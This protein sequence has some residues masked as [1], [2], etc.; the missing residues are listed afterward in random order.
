MA[1]EVKL[2][3]RGFFGALAAVGGS[4][5]ALE[6]A[7]KPGARPRNIIWMVAD[8]MSP[9]VLPMAEH[10][11]RMVRGKGLLW[12]AL[13]DRR[14][15][16]R[17]LMDMASLN[18][19]VTDSS[20]ASSSWGSG[21]RIFNGMVNM[22]PDGTKL[23]PLAAIA[24]DKGKRVGLVTTAT[25][26]HATPAG[27][28]SAERRRDDEHLIAEQY[29]RNADVI[30]GG[31]LKF[32]DA[33]TRK[34]GKDLIGEFR[35][36]GYAW[37]ARKQSLSAARN[38]DK[39][40]GLFS[41]SHVPYTIDHRADATL[42]QNVPTLAE[43][44]GAALASLSRGR[45]GFLLQVEGARVDHAAHNNDAAALLW[46]QIAF[47]DAIEVVLQFAE[48][49]PETLVVITSDHGNS[50]PGLN[51]MGDEYTES[52]KCFERLA[53]ITRSFEHVNPRLGAKGEYTMK[54]SAA[55]GNAS[56]PSV[57]HV[58][59][60]AQEVFG[61][62]FSNDEAEAVRNSVAGEKRLSLNR[63][64]DKPV[65]ILGQAVG[66]HIGV[67]WT[68]TQHTSDYVLITALGPGSQRFA[69]HVTNTDVFPALTAFMGSS[70]RNPAIDASKASQF[71]QAAFLR[72][73]RPDW[74]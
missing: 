45:N 53:R 36:Q 52:T 48:K 3:R 71:K 38:N 6:A 10:F 56:K 22:L 21:S 11:S 20:A 74:A 14:E 73:E 26:T 32:F 35:K 62:T 57:D 44:T 46:D 43:M 33:K 61:F 54:Q 24:R 31:G 47:D 37:V 58:Q 16:S 9:S 15:V 63:Q 28:A 8:G 41:P 23:T 13:I 55:G 2:G 4:L 29:L 65:G 1:L 25:V 27:F 69:G 42:Q 34:D 5:E 60:I 7:Q 64:L 30:L 51:G 12:R 72:R 18:S 50:N 40:L 68:G 19:M 59:T 17:G 70:F 39:V 67:G 66:N 49:N